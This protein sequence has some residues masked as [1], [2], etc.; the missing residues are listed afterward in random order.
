MIQALERVVEFNFFLSHLRV[1]GLTLCLCWLWCLMATIIYMNSR[2]GSILPFLFLLSF[3][4]IPLSAEGFT[5][6]A[7]SIERSPFLTAYQAWKKK[8]N[9][10]RLPPLGE[11]DP[12]WEDME[13]LLP[14]ATLREEIQWL[15]T[16]SERKSWSEFQGPVGPPGTN[17]AGV[18]QCVNGTD[19]ANGPEEVHNP[20]DPVSTP[21]DVKG[22]EGPPGKHKNVI[23]IDNTL[24]GKSCCCESDACVRVPSQCQ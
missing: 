14:G 15:L 16:Y 17:G 7:E 22:A 10:I 5:K 23:Y 11:S 20:P 3:S 21:P 1:Y 8:E 18:S 9:P 2:R 6:S 19:G 13:I 4:T 24:R 12:V